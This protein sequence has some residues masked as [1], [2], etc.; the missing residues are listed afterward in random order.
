MKE[1]YIRKGNSEDTKDILIIGEE[2]YLG[3]RDNSG[4]KPNKGST[5]KPLV[6]KDPFT[7]AKG[8]TYIH[9]VKN[10]PL[11]NGKWNRDLA[12]HE[13]IKHACRDLVRWDGE[14]DEGLVRSRE[15]FR[16]LNGD[17]EYTAKELRKRIDYA[18]HGHDSDFVPEPEEEPEKDPSTKNLTILFFGLLAAFIL[19]WVFF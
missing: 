5:F 10:I 6:K 1:L 17:A 13:F 7:G 12:V 3:S 18:I 15:A 9:C 11:D 14:A 16:V 8:L 19:L 2:S 4:Y